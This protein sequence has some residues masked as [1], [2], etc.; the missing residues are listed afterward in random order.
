M[1]KTQVQFEKEALKKVIMEHM[2][3]EQTERLCDYAQEEIFEMIETRAFHSR[4]YNATDSYVWAVYYGG[5]LKGSGFTGAKMAT[6]NSYLHEWSKNS[7]KAVDGRQAAQDFLDTYTPRRKKGWEV[8]WCAA[9]PYTAYLEGGFTM[10]KSGRAYQFDVMSQRYDHI[11]G[12][13]GAKCKVT[14]KVN[15]PA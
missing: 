13:L 6:K 8:V 10:V 9:A 12:V 3:K 5:K 11:K 4:T 14:M 1:K 7:R 15:Y 2:V